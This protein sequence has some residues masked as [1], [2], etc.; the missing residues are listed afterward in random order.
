MRAF[1]FTDDSWGPWSQSGSRTFLFFTRKHG[2]WRPKESDQP[3]VPKTVFLSRKRYQARS[4][5][6]LLRKCKCLPYIS[7]CCWISDYRSE[8]D[9]SMTPPYGLRSSNTFPMRLFL[10]LY[11]D[12]NFWRCGINPFYSVERSFLITSLEKWKENSSFPK[13][14]I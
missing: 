6:R 11:P 13:H 4:S 8:A 1:R 12:M 9:K 5:P 2:D 10:G 7:I 3:P 14:L